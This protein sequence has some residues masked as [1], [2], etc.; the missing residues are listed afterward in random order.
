MSG[1]LSGGYF[2]VYP[3]HDDLPDPEIRTLITNFYRASDRADRNELW[4]SYFTKDA[5][6]IMGSDGGK[7]E[8]GRFQDRGS[9]GEEGN[10]GQECECMLFGDVKLQTKEGESLIVPW[11][12]HAI[13][14]KVG[15]GDKEWKFR[16]YQ[17]WLQ[18]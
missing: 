5:Q 10:L 1:S 4:I 3:H 14:Q 8:K 12:G 18:K 9:S 17:V 15:N 13:L 11:A 7:G 6:V 2:P 16:H